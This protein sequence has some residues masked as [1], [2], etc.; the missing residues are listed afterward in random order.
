MSG[1]IARIAG[2][3]AAGILTWLGGLLGVE[4]SPEDNAALAGVIVSVILIIYGVVHKQID[5]RVNPADAAD[6]SL[7]ERGKEQTGN[8]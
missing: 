5:K 3:L 2:A 6:T 4:F 8:A 7:I 1:I